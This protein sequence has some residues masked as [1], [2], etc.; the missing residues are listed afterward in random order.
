MSLKSLRVKNFTA[1]S[2]LDVEFSPGLN[3]II[4]ENASGKSHLLKLG[5]VTAYVAYESSR[6]EREMPG[7]M[8]A[9]TTKSWL[10]RRIAEKLVGVFKPDT[11]GRLCRRGRGRAKSE[12]R[13]DFGSHAAL[14]F[15]FT[16]NNL[17]EVVLQSSPVQAQYDPPIF[18]P[19]KEALSLYPGFTS[20]YETREIAL[21]E[22]YYDLCKFLSV[23]LLRGPYAPA[24]ATIVKP[25]EKIMG[26]KVRMSAGRF[27]LR[28]P[29]QGFME[30]SLVAEGFRKLAML[31]YLA[32][33]GSLTDKGMLFWDEPEANLNP[34]IM[35]QVAQTLT[36]LV[37]SGVQ[38]ITATH[39]LFIMKE[40]SYLVEKSKTAI[41]AR[42]FCLR[43]EGSDVELEHGELLEDL[44]TITALDEVLS[45]D[46]REQALF[47]EGE[48]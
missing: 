5:Y 32:V 16:S 22:T 31:T 10:Q 36:A 23:P 28:L 41:P 1:F 8:L 3:V 19:A 42:F 9:G 39:S 7:G 26:G 47:H 4:G 33:N 13:T 2:D 38:V 40:L 30:I 29:G 34:R 14:R 37:L 43:L 48:Q 18:F 17:K 25:L 44:E 24:I 20:L 45:Q 35:T 11:L 46:D 15:S 21:D 12:I 6:R 27:Y